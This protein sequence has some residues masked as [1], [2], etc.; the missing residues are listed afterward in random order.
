MQHAI[1]FL[2]IRAFSFLPMLVSFV[3]FSTFRGVMEVGTAVKVALAA[4]FV[5]LVLDP[6]FIHVLGLGVRGS[7][8]AAV[9]GDLVNSIIYFRLLS[10]KNLIRWEKIS[11]L[12]S[13]RSIAPLLEGGIALQIRSFVINL[14][15][16]MVTRVIQSIDENGI[17]PAAHALA[18]QTFMMGGI[19]LGALGMATQ[20]MI[21]NALQ[22]RKDDTSENGG[23]SVPYVQALTR[24]L[25]QWGVGVGVVIGIL[26]F[27]FLPIILKSSPL[28]EV[29]EAARVPA[30]LSI[31]FQWIN[32]LVNVG[33]GVMMGNG[34]FVRLATNMIVAAI[35][36]VGALLF[37]PNMLGL[38]G[39]W[40]SLAIFVLLRA[41]GVFVFLLSQKSIDAAKKGP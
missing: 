18:M 33:E 11:R 3:G 12:P 26:E 28:Q 21:P 5:T 22:R 27:V 4:N 10:S 24:R 14:T 35:G 29:R 41:S 19:F 1:P 30:L 9:S 16:L 23:A 15:Q 40:C 2:R 20:T 31:S 8:F 17:A 13:W 36:Y 38:T 25:L 7:A 39:V 34:R 32:G 37:F 6:V